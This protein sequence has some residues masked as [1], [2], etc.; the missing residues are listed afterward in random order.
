MEIMSI[1]LQ[2]L[3]TLL[4]KL[5]GKFSALPVSYE[6]HMYETVLNS[7]NTR[8]REAMNKLQRQKLKLIGEA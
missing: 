7:L 6:A 1:E 2:K 3:N 5:R 4:T 8:L